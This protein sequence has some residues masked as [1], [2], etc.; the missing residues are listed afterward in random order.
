M[1]AANAEHDRETRGLTAS[2]WRHN[3]SSNTLDGTSVSRAHIGTKRSKTLAA[4][5][6]PELP[7]VVFSGELGAEASNIRRLTLTAK[8]SGGD[9]I[10]K[11][12]RSHLRLFNENMVELGS[13]AGTISEVSGGGSVITNDAQAAGIFDSRSSDGVLLVDIEDVTGA[14]VGDLILL[15]EPIDQ[16]GAKLFVPVTFA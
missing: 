12:V 6:N 11:A 1:N 16:Q 9:T 15:V 7:P 4:Q 10:K 2:P 8:S 13:A 5:T 14:L 3:M